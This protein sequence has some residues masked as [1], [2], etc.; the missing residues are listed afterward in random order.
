MAYRGRSFLFVAGFFSAVVGL[1]G[2]R[3]GDLPVAC[4][5]HATEFREQKEAEEAPL[6]T[7]VPDTGPYP[8]AFQL[9]EEGVNRLLGKKITEADI[10]FTGTLDFGAAGF[11]FEPEGEPVITFGELPHCSSCL[12]LSLEFQVQLLNAGEPDS[13][14]FGEV[15]LSVP[16]ELAADEAGGVTTLFADYGRI[17]VEEIS[18]SVKGISLTPDEHAQYAGAIGILLTEKLQEEFGQ[19]ELMSIGSWTIGGGN[20]RLLARE[21]L[22]F[23]DHGKLALGMQTNLPLPD[24]AGLFLDAP[25]PEGTPMAVT[26][27]S[28]I[29]LSMSHRMLAEG[30]IPRRYD[31]N[32]QPDDLG[33]YAVTLDRMVGNARGAQQLDAE[34]NVWRIADGLCGNV[35][36]AMPLTLE[37]TENRKGFRVAAGGATLLSGEGSGLQALE[38]KELVDQNEALIDTFRRE[39]ADSVGNTINYDAFDVEGSLIVVEVDD[40]TV[41]QLEVNSLLDFRIF[42]DP[43]AAAPG[44]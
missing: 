8:V 41:N 6:R 26:F 15:E 32:G 24:A 14:G 42:D 10:P 7:P 43:N 5:H 35:R 27:D 31:D 25:L 12:L 9:T 30:Q 20:I 19:L 29:F 36:A 39:L 17:N 2:C 38:E 4:D 40:L 28:R 18:L 3:G 1:N 44:E 37:V 22:V 11:E 33:I 23:P 13:T 21:L 16:M 34:F